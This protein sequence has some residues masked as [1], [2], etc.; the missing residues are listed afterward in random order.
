MNYSPFDFVQDVMVAVNRTGVIP[1]ETDRDYKMPYAWQRAQADRAIGTIEFLNRAVSAMEVLLSEAVGP[2]GISP[3]EFARPD[4]WRERAVAILQPI[5]KA[6][7][8]RRKLP[9]QLQAV[10][11]KV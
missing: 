11:K 5:K 6:S 9:P 2:A 4:G 10:S 3:Q 1:P 7:A 8:Q